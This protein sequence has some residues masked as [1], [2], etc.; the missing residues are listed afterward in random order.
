M[1]ETK[2]KGPDGNII[3]VKHPDG[4]SQDDIFEFAKQNFKPQTGPDL[5]AIP[6]W[7]QGGPSQTPNEPRGIMA[8]VGEGAS[9][10]FGES[11][12][13]PEDASKYPILSK[14]MEGLQLPGRVAGGALGAGAGLVSGVAE[15]AGMPTAEAD[16][17]M[18]DIP[19][20][21]TAAGV[22]A[23]VMRPGPK[24]Q[25]VTRKVETPTLDKIERTIG[26]P[27]TPEDMGIA[28]ESGVKGAQ[29]AQQAQTDALYGR[30]M[31][32]PGQFHAGAFEGVGSKLKGEI[33][34]DPTIIV[35][36][37]TPQT[38]KAIS[39]LDR[40]LSELKIENKVGPGQPAA[41]Q[42]NIVGINLRGIEQVRKN[43]NQMYRDIGP[44]NKTDRRAFKRL[45][46]GFDARIEKTIEEGLFSGDPKV[47]D[48]IKAARASASEGFK[49]YG[50][51][52]R[53]DA[54]TATMAK[55]H[56]GKKSPQSI[57]NMLI[58]ASRVGARDLAE[59]MVNRLSATM[60]EET[61]HA[62]REAVFTAAKGQKAG[63]RQLYDTN[64]GKKLFDPYQRDLMRRYDMAQKSDTKGK[65]N[66]MIGKAL[67]SAVVHKVT[68]PL[69]PV[70]RPIARAG[71]RALHKYGGPIE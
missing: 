19:I 67:T 58:N 25:T 13:K 17:L 71:A 37:T 62:I 34:Q 20:A 22:E 12:V 54:V 4:A 10:G 61:M 18:R 52:Q 30:A 15:K 27:R 7:Q 5:A 32:E 36:A 60:P 66:G 16:R 48:M 33:G 64:F 24:P 23:G 43:L 49:L 51:G 9:A 39:Y 40:G 11:R 26:K 44:I 69:G 8:R 42:G 3:T 35:D 55:I 38:A 1:P 57:A 14:I 28:I 47:L 2:V 41:A 6:G 50:P 70:L 29:R 45:M 59:P 53:G 21:A 63:L 56:G 46:E 31:G 68:G 65:L